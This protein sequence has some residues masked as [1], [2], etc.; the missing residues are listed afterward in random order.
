MADGT[1]TCLNLMFVLACCIPDYRALARV[2][3]WSGSIPFPCHKPR[4]SQ[5]TCVMKPNML[6]PTLSPKATHKIQALMYLDLTRTDISIRTT[7]RNTGP[8]GL[9]EGTCQSQRCRFSQ[10]TPIGKG[11]QLG[12]PRVSGQVSLSGNAR[13]KATCREGLCCL[14]TVRSGFV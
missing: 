12:S 1:T 2:S 5:V 13:Q 10:W 3:E 14:A 6:V 4:I 11:R 9:T 8:A 7:G